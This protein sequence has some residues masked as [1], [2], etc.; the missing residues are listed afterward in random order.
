MSEPTTDYDSPW[1]EAIE[2]YFHAFMALFFPLAHADIDWTRGYEFLDTELQQVVRDA[3]LGRRL[4]DKLV[5]VWLHDGV[6]AW[7]LIHIEVQG[8]VDTDFPLR[9]YIYN[10]R[11]FDRYKRPIISLAVLGDERADWRPN[12]YGYAL[13][14]CDVR[15]RFPIVKLLD[16]GTQWAIL[17]QSNNPFAV[18]V[19][20]H[21]KTQATRRDVAQRLEWKLRLVRGLYERGY[22]REDVLELF[23]FIDWL[24]A[25]P[26]DAER[27][28]RVAL[29]AYEEEQQMT[30]VTSVERLAKQE[31]IEQGIEQ[32]IKQGIEQGIKQGIEQ[33]I[34]QGIIQGLRDSIIEMLTTRFAAVPESTRTVLAQTD[35]PAQLKQWLR[36]AV[37]VDSIEDFERVVTSHEI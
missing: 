10:Y 6:E 4:A 13:W 30:Y 31:G 21:L 37:T 5:K 14:G 16:Y 32:G 3:E 28:F 2:R 36:V 35:D 34:E 7:V 29:E 15:L 12:E 20:A 9:M 23:R 19:M 25:L 11:L 17:E 8:Q 33:G 24:M 18:M 27:A 22:G 1:K 26:T